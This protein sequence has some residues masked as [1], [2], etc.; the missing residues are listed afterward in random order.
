MSESLWNHLDKRER[1]RTYLKKGLLRNTGQLYLYFDEMTNGGQI[2]GKFYKGTG[3]LIKQ[4]NSG[5]F[6][7]LTCGHSFVAND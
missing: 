1:D 6:L 5:L 7:G 4:L 2:K 3:F